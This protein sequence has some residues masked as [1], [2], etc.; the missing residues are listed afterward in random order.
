VD[1]PQELSA[2]DK[3]CRS[4]GIG[5]VDCKKAFLESLMKTLGPIQERH[6]DLSA[7]PQE[8]QQ[9]LD[10][11][12]EHCRRIASETILETKKKLGLKQVWKI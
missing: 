6:R 11:G 1:T 9:R 7:R 8:V 10:A 4:A 5:C 3:G 12:A 2:I